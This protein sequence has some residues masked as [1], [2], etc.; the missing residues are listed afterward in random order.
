LIVHALD[1]IKVKMGTASMPQSPIEGKGA[2]TVGRLGND[3][4]PIEISNIL[5]SDR[6]SEDKLLV[7]VKADFSTLDGDDISFGTGEV[8]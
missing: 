7:I 3:C 1:I 5:L 6:S 2:G 8:E 4:V